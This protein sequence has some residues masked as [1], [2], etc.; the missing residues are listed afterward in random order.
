MAYR[1]RRPVLHRVLTLSWTLILVFGWTS[2]GAAQEGFNWKRFAGAKIHVVN[3]SM[4][5]VDLITA[6]IPE[7]KTLTGIDVEFE[8]IPGAAL[9]AYA[10]KLNAEFTSKSKSID[11]FVAYAPQFS[12]SFHR[13]GWYE[14]LDKYLKDASLVDPAYDVADFLPGILKTSSVSETLV[15]VPFYATT[16]MLYY[17]KDLFAQQG[18]KVPDTFEDLERAAKQLTARDRGMYGIV[19]R[20]RGGQ[21]VLG[22]GS[23]FYGQGGTWFDRAGAPQVNSAAALWAYETYGRVLRL[24]GPP[25]PA[26]LSRLDGQNL[27]ST[28]KA[29]MWIDDTDGVPWLQ[30]PT[31]T[32]VADNVGYALMPRGSS[33]RKPISTTNYLSISAASERKGAAWYF[34]QWATSRATMLKAQL[35]GTPSAR[36]SSWKDPAFLATVA[37]K[38]PDYVENFMKSFENGNPDWIPPIAGAQ[39]ARDAIGQAIIAGISGGDIKAAADRANED[40][41]RIVAKE[42]R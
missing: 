39:E 27:F 16:S 22:W 1:R 42:R 36:S 9:A 29:A 3:Y 33:G 18:I 8:L 31:K 2:P 25:G 32:P 6:L 13:A 12:Y 15:G 24:Y 34:V 11:V 10:Q 21:A 38:H 20:G 41:A 28:G 23:W 26:N 14:P 17:R 40:L 30:D 4:G 5:W 35:K 7:F 19:Y 37:A